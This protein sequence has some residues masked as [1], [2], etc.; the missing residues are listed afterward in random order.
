MK[1]IFKIS[2]VVSA[3]V[4]VLLMSSC[5]TTKPLYSWYD[6]QEDYYNYVKKADKDSLDDLI[7]TYDK[8]I[9]EQKA[10]RGIVPPGIYADYGYILLEQG[11]TKEAK[12]M[13]AKEIE[14]YP[15]AETFVGT[16]LKR[17]K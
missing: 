5:T 2:T 14:L 15:E 16:I 10:L 8:I 4:L 6:Y 13:L 3:T 7:K 1:K 11:K 9:A 12:A 17:I